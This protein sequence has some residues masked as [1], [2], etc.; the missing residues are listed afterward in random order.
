[1]LSAE[2]LQMRLPIHISHQNAAQLLWSTSRVHFHCATIYIQLCNRLSSISTLLFSVRANELPLK[3]EAQALNWQLYIN[4]LQ[5]KFQVIIFCNYY[6]GTPI[7]NPPHNL[8]K[9]IVRWNRRL[10]CMHNING[11][12][13]VKD[14]VDRWKKSCYWC[15]TCGTTHRRTSVGLPPLISG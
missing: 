11:L 6:P 4:I 15:N 2:Q 7:L 14:A 9:T 3:N 1:M 10:L 13:I 8:K 5:P 12:P